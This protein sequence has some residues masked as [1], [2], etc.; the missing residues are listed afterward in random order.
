VNLTP[1]LDSLMAQSLTFT[2]AFSN[3]KKSIEG[4]PAITAS[5]PTWMNEP[6]ITSA[7]GSNQAQ[8]IASL[9]KTEGYYTAFFHGATN[10]SMGFDAFANLSGYTD[11]YGRYEYSNDEDYDG[12]WG[13][14]DEEFL[15]Y[16]AQT[17]NKK[18]EP[19]FA[20]L[21]TL[22]SHHPYKIPSKYE[23]KFKEGVYDNAKCIS[24]ADYSLKYF[25][26][27]IKKMPWYNNTLFVLC[28]DH[29]GIS[30]DKFYENKIGNNTIPII[31]FMPNS[32]LKGFDTTITQQID[33]MP[34]I[35]QYLN[36]NKP[37]YSFGKSVFDTTANHFAFTFNSGIYQYTNNN[38]TLEF[39]GEKATGLFQYK[40]DSLLKNNLIK[41]EKMV[42]NELELKTK[43]IIQTYQQS[44]INNKMSND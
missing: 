16:T 5:I 8:S 35:L 27:T 29:T 21:F 38:Y 40:K 10:G 37:F 43:A 1:F 39:D 18:Q 33:I 28:A 25:F 42:A 6:Y 11:Y 36:Y 34:S 44:L 19:F 20:T 41:T 12:S 7:Y 23:S 31:Y 24:Y 17:L 14:W 13:I 9:L 26:E 2:N 3:G 30:G 22:T 15:Q 4:I 32:E